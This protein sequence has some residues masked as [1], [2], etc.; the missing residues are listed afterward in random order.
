M[1]LHTSL[2][3]ELA[4]MTENLFYLQKQKKPALAKSALLR[5]LKPRAILLGELVISD[6]AP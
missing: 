3:G 1:G 2:S 6:T 4:C 5:W